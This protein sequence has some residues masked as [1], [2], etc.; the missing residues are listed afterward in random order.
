LAAQVH[1]AAAAGWDQCVI[2][3]V[4]GEDPRPEVGHLPPDRIRPLVFDQNNLDFPVPGMS[5]VMPYRSSVFS[6]LS[7]MQLS[8]Y[9]QAWQKHIAEVAADFQPDLIQSHHVWLMSALI[10]DILPRTPVV[11]QCHATGLR[12]MALCPHLAGEV[13]AGCARNDRFLVLSESH[14]KQLAESLGIPAA[15]IHIVGAG[16]REEIFNLP[17]REQRRQDSLLYIG[18]YSAAKGLP[19][20]LDAF[21]RLAHQNDQLELHIAGSG[22]GPEAAALRDRMTSLAPRVILHGQLDQPALANLM[23]ECE[24]CVLPS[25]YEGVP[26]VLVEALACGCRL[27]ATRIPGIEEQ[28]APD[29][30]SFI[31]LVPLPRLVSIDQPHPGDHPLFVDN[32][33]A[34]V[35]T[36]L[37]E[38]PPAERI[39]QLRTSLLPFTWQAVWERIAAVWSELL[40]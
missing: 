40:A 16:Y 5:D 15:H 11:T 8:K 13:K 21:E 28:L 27:V 17:P 18:K 19:W 39:N 10:K 2:V 34:A 14:A 29:L 38:P 6:T 32:L 33:A 3:G 24:V 23:R 1:H 20:L 30:D 31:Q 7:P 4:P 25:F 9:R 35:S 12:Q 22:A 36:A 37:E 26:L